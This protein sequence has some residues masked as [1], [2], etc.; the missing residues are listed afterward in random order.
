MVAATSPRRS[1]ASATAIARVDLPLAIGP[2]ITMTSGS[3]RS[4]V[5][6]DLRALQLAA[7]VD[8]DRLPFG[9]DIERG[10]AGFAV[11]V[12]RLLHAAE[13]EVHLGAGR[14]GVDV[15]DAGLQVA[16]RLERLVDVA[17]ED[18]RREAVLDAVRG[19]NRILEGV[20]RDQRRGRPEDL[21]LRDAHLRVDVGEHGR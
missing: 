11:A 10:L 7:V 19:A 20:D 8:V 17:R 5:V 3:G 9:E 12:A 1:N 13:R 15:G 21:L 4:L 6:V 2:P 14:A 18:R 16:H